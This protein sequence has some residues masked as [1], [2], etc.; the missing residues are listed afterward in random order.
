MILQRWVEALAHRRTQSATSPL[1]P[2]LI[3]SEVSMGILLNGSRSVHRWASCFYTWTEYLEK[4]ACT[5]K[6]KQKKTGSRKN[7]CI[8]LPATTPTPAERRG[9]GRRRRNDWL[10]SAWHWRVQCVCVSPELISVLVIIIFRYIMTHTCATWGKCS[11]RNGAGRIHP[12]TSK[13][14]TP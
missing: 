3:P 4:Q 5:N 12:V 2:E 9:L 7:T 14:F 8:S 10:S 13:H 11:W 1:R 6:T